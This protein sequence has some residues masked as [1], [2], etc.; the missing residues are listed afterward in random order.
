MNTR[1]PLLLGGNCQVVLGAV[2]DMPDQPR[3]NWRAVGGL[4]H[5]CERAVV[6]VDFQ[7][8]WTAMCAECYGDYREMLG[9]LGT[10]SVGVTSVRR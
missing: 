3:Q 5:C 4:A 1:K 8:H 9:Y 10:A 6:E 7:G 2:S